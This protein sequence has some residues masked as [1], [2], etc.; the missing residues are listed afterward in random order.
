MMRFAR[1]DFRFWIF[2]A[3]DARHR[4]D[5][6]RAAILDCGIVRLRAKL[7]LSPVI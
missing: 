5:P 4:C 2:L 3:Y 1:R 7:K 6:S